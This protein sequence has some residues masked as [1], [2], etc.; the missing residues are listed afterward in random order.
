MKA[1]RKAAASTALDPIIPIKE[2]S[3]I[4]C[5]SM[6]GIYAAINAGHLRSHLRGRQ[7]FV[8]ESAVVE[9]LNYLESESDAGRPVTYR[10]RGV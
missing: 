6:P 1:K 7:R 5:M 8:R 3:R 2:V 10:P 9:W 4:A